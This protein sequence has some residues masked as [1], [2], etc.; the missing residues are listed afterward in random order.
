M[1]FEAHER[2]CRT[3]ELR[4]FMELIASRLTAPIMDP[5]LNTVLDPDAADRERYISY[6][7]G[8]M[9]ARLGIVADYMG[10]C[11]TKLEALEA[12]DARTKVEA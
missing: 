12:M 8:A 10:I 3:A 9:E 6:A 2:R 7:M 1:D 5:Q 4:S 11:F